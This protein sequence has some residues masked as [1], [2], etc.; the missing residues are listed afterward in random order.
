MKIGGQNETGNLRWVLMK[1]PRDAFLSQDYIQL[2]WKEL[3]Y[4]RP[5]DYSRA[6]DEYEKFSEA[7]R[8]SGTNIEYLPS[9]HRCRL[10]SIYVRDTGFPT[11]NGM[12]VG[13]MGKRLRQAE[14]EALKDFLRQRSIPILGEIKEEGTFEG[15]DALWLDEKT[16]AVGEG[17]RTN[18]EGIRQLRGL[19]S[20]FGVEVL[21]VALPHWEGPDDVF[22]LM[23]IISPITPRLA[24][25][26]SRL[27]PVPFRRVLLSRG[28]KLIEV[29]DE[30]FGSMAGNILSLGSQCCLML[31]GNSQTRRLLESAGVEAVEFQGQEICLLGMGG[32]TCL[33]RPI[34]RD[35]SY[36]ESP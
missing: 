32:P 14:T 28:V 15:G 21:S 10:D 6:L 9:D 4:S 26:Y 23:S 12:I 16:L 8:E 36:Q 25:V 34:K 7:I 17:Y 19:L 35:L 27:M 22:H 30:E 1:H 3:N 18:R 29:P 24:V 5:P 20:N 31:E 2:H 33:A 11:D 13:R